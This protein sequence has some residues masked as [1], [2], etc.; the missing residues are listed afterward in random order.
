MPTYDYECENHE[1]E[2]K[3]EHFQSI[4]SPLL[5]KCPKCNKLKL[6]RLIGSGGGVIFK[7]E[8]F[9]ENDYKKKK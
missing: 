4:T 6:V 7:G 1:C 3:F 2:H 5:K 9:Y 8:G